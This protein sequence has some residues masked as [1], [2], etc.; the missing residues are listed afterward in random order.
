MTSSKPHVSSLWPA[1]GKR[2]TNMSSTSELEIKLITG[3]G[4]RAGVNLSW[5]GGGMVWCGGMES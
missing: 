1:M 2:R 5:W 3:G 4:R